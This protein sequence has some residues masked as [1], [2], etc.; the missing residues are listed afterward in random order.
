MKIHKLY[1][2]VLNLK[3][4]SHEAACRDIHA[5][6]RGPVPPEDKP[7]DLRE[8]QWFDCYNQLH[9]TM[10][11]VT[12]DSDVPNASFELGPKCRALI[13]TG[14][15]FHMGVEF[16]ARLHPRSGLAWKNG[17]TLINAEGIIDSDYDQ[18]IFIP[19]YNTTNIPFLINHGDRIAQVE[20]IQPY[21]RVSHITY[22]ESTRKK[23]R[24]TNRKGGFGSTGV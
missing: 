7:A 13:P 1:P 5:H 12:Y 8:I 3:L 11:E 9:K 4:A 19:L 21:R 16:S 20:I 18:E 2:N 22:T 23:D 15:V 17:I 24:S 10:P 14:M 6:F